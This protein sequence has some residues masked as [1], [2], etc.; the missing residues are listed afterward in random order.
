MAKLALPNIVRGFP[1]GRMVSL[2]ISVARGHIPCVGKEVVMLKYRLVIGIVVL[3]TAL[4]CGRGK[5][6]READRA[7]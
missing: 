1:M 5:D 4:F 7:R 6:G 2:A 3:S